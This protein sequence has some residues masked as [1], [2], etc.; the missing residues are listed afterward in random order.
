MRPPNFQNRRRRVE[1]GTS[2][3][4]PVFLGVSLIAAKASTLLSDYLPKRLSKPT[5]SGRAKYCRWSLKR[6]RCLTSA[7]QLLW[8]LSLPPEASGWGQ[9]QT[10]LRMVHW[11]VHEG[12][13]QGSPAESFSFLSCCPTESCFCS[14]SSEAHNLHQTE[15]QIGMFCSGWGAARLMWRWNRSLFKK[16]RTQAEG[17]CFEI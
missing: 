3:R 7:S 4:I 17:G 8:A 10:G 5:G 15:E 2:V 6:I 1:D 9:T 13:N 16:Q 12:W 11:C 14:G